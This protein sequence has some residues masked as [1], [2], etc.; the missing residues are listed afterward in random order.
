MHYNHGGMPAAPSQAIM[1]GPLSM[2]HMKMMKNLGGDV[3]GISYKNNGGNVQ[4]EMAMKFH[5]NQKAPLGGNP[6]K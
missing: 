3:A 5:P 2:N 4:E 1:T 6:V